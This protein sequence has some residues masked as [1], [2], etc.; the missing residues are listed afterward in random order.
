MNLN[1]NSQVIFTFRGKDVIVQCDDHNRIK[2]IFEKFAIKSQAN[3]DLLY[4]LYGGN[5]I[6]EELTL[7]ELYNPID[8][9]EK[10]I[11]ILVYEMN[12]AILDEEGELIKSKEI[13]CPKCYEI[14]LIKIKDYK[15][16]L[17][18]CK[19][20]HCTKDI[21]LDEF[22]NTQ[23]INISKI[24]CNNCNKNNKSKT[25]NNKFYK[26]LTCKQNLCP[27][28]KLKHDKSHENNIIDYDNKNYICDIHNDF[29]NSY[30]DECNKNLCMLC[31]NDHDNGHNMIEYRKV[32]EDK[33]KIKKELDEFNKNIDKL[34]DEIRGIIQK[35]NKIISNMKI[36]YEINKNILENKFAN[37]EKNYEMLKNIKEIKNNIKESDI[38]NVIKENNLELKL[39]K[40]IEIY[41]KMKNEYTMK[42]K[43][44]ID[45][46]LIRKT[47]TVDPNKNN[48]INQMLNYPNMLNNP[49]MMMNNPNMMMGYPGGMQ[50]M[51]LNYPSG[52][53]NPIG[54]NNPNIIMNNQNM[55]SFYQNMMMNQ[56]NMNQNMMNQNM[57]MNNQY[58][59]MNMNPNINNPFEFQLHNEDKKNKEKEKGEK[60]IDK[61]DEKKIGKKE[62]DKKIDKKDEQK[63]VKKE[64]EKKIDKKDE[65]KIGKKE[66][67]KKID[68]KDEQKNVIKKDKEI[69]LCN[70]INKKDKKNEEKDMNENKK[71]NKDV[72]KEDKSIKKEEGVLITL[73]FY[74]TQNKKYIPIRIRDDEKLQKAINIFKNFSSR[75]KKNDKYMYNGKE[76]DSELIIRESGLKHS[77]I[78]EVIE[79]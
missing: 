63:N 74:I 35:L 37:Y 17:Y 23:K 56:N 20:L 64:E 5:I 3:K 4:F 11:T 68:K 22:E 62:E 47:A 67:E 18:D 40:L 38:N 45:E 15:I 30:C 6:N 26:C 29:Y 59:F 9:K 39:K 69:K 10:K 48:N 53:M 19:N 65:K 72:K 16:K 14:C 1:L 79:K 7:E 28:C 60:K 61:K 55:G 2:D 44:Y 32:I 42:N 41:E 76:L 13:I 78:I 21:L 75:D 8:K 66:E 70:N 46:D 54:M 31:Q 24:I 12:D 36:Y 51:A 57:M 77:S 49:N 73:R 43:D 71:Y 25:Y 34:N 33:G 27:E 52:M 50:Q 58:Q